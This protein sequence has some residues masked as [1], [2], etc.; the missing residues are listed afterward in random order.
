MNKEDCFI[1]CY[2]VSCRKYRQNIEYSV[3]VKPMNVQY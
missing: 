3:K 2:Y 1:K